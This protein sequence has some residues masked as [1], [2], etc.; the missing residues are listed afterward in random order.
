MLPS[1]AVVAGCR[2]ERL[3]ADAPSKRARL[4]PKMN[5]NSE[6]RVKLIS[7]QSLRQ[8][9]RFSDN[10]GGAL[11]HLESIRR[12]AATGMACR[13]YQRRRD[14]G[15]ILKTPDYQGWQRNRPSQSQ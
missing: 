7:E 11:N 13:R 2:Q 10:A 8:H 1:A 14:S 15:S 4:L 6:Q 5:S 9:G 3:A 12:P